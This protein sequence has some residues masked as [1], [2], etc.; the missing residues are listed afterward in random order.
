MYMRG[1]GSGV[2]VDPL[3]MNMIERGQQEAPNET[4]EAQ[5]SASYPHESPI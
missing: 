4:G 5:N 1:R 3:R 2:V